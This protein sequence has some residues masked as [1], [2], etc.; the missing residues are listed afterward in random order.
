[1]SPGWLTRGMAPCQAGPFEA[2]GHVSRASDILLRTF[3]PELGTKGTGGTWGAQPG[4]SGGH[5]LL[6]PDDP[7]HPLPA[8]VREDLREAPG[9]LG[10]CMGGTA[11]RLVL[12]CWPLVGRDLVPLG[13]SVQGLGEGRPQVSVPS[14][15][16]PTG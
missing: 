5:F 1:M 16:L 6:A 14:T 9:G 11:L 2:G 8:A 4:T 12:A 15:P 13:L 7:Q 3:G 10:P